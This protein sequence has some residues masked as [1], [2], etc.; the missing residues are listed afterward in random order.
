MKKI[1]VGHRCSGLNQNLKK[2]RK[3]KKWKE[4]IND[5]GGLAASDFK[6]VS[7]VLILN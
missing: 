1:L 2:R 6:L 3:K 7:M 5:W 4:I